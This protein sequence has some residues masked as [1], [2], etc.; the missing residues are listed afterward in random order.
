MLPISRHFA[1]FSCNDDRMPAMRP[2]NKEFSPL[3][4]SDPYISDQTTQLEQLYSEGNDLID[5]IRTADAPRIYI[6]SGPSGV[7]KDTVIEQL[8]E[9]F[10]TAQ[11]VVTATTR[12]MRAGEIDGVHYQFMAKDDFV[13][14]IESNAFIENALV[15][16]NHYGVPKQ[17]I[18]DGLAQN[19]DVIIKV[20][21]KGAATLRRLIPN[22]I[23]IFLAPE[24]MEALLA[25]LRDRK[26][27]DPE[28]LMKRFRTASQ[29]LAEVTN[30]DYVVFNEDDQ[31][32]AAVSSIVRIVH[33]E[34]L[35]VVR[36]E[37]T[38]P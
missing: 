38:V 29:E 20:D 37:I 1:V 34:R 36:P 6:I 33:V 16:D 31:L 4:T 7:G 18:I 5:E 32:D 23:S 22:T 2:P 13:A 21:V 26:T 8:R 12:P 14:G 19:R 9:A 10:P 17:P 15:Y 25:R 30:F 3:S 24:S 35:K 27:D 11:Y 28:V